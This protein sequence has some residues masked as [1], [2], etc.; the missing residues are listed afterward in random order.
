MVNYACIE[1]VMKP[2]MANQALITNNA[3]I[4]EEILRACQDQLNSALKK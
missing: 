3:R 2:G 4:C 1:N